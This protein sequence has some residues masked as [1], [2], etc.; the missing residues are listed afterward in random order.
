MNQKFS[1]TLFAA[2]LPMFLLECGHM[3]RQHC[4]WAEFTT[5][6]GVSDLF[7]LGAAFS[8]LVVG[9][10]GIQLPRTSGGQTRADDPPKD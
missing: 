5:T 8:A 1:I 2:G 4:A 3:V 10:L 9:A 6:E 7:V